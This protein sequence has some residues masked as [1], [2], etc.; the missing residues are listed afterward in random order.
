MGY[1]HQIEA[2]LSVFA[3]LSDVFNG[4]RFV[5]VL[6]TVQFS[7]TY[8]RIQPGRVAFIGLS[9]SFGTIKNGKPQPFE[10]DAAG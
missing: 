8:E 9:H 10:F 7:Q 5:R 3:T 1:R 4:Q 2:N 6:D